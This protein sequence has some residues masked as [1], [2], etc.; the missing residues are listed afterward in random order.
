MFQQFVSLVKQIVET[1][2]AEREADVL[3]SYPVA[4][5]LK[6]LFVSVSYTALTYSTVLTCRN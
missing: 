2:L 4:S 5:N 6:Y 3:L 1:F